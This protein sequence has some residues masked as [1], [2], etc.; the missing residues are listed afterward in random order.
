VF[1]VGTFSKSLFPAL[2]LGFVV[3]P[4]W[5]RRALVAAKQ[6]SDWHG[7]VL[8]QDTLAAFVAEGHLARHIRKMRKVY[9]ERRATL[10]EALTHHCGDLLQP[11]PAD[12]GLHL[13]ASGPFDGALVAKAADKG[14]A[15]QALDR[16]AAAQAPSHGLAFGYGMI[17]ADQIDEAICRL[18]P[19]LRDANDKARARTM[20]GGRGRGA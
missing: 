7:P 8:A 18:T 5:A 14:I 15:L 13:A 9:G 17:A 6:V 16:Y 10:I 1:Y 20:R 12:S 19:L 3:T 2:R 4:S 11:I